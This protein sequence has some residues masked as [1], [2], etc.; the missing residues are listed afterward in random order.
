MTHAVVS[1]A[2]PAVSGD[3]S[4]ILSYV[5]QKEPV[6]A[7]A[8]TI[9]FLGWLGTILV[10][11]KVVGTQ[12]WTSMTQTA[13]LLLIPIV[14]LGIGWLVRNVLNSPWTTKLEREAHISTVSD[15]QARLDAAELALKHS[16]LLTDADFGRMA[17]VLKEHQADVIKQLAAANVVVS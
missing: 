4:S 6:M 5:T 10:G 7:A 17:V 13:T 1:N 8:V 11:H 12:Q 2:T 9:W 15:L 3:G 16:G 14:T